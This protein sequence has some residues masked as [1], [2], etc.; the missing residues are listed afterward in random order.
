M[1]AVE[2]TNKPATV[3]G[4]LVTSVAVIATQRT[5][6]TNYAG[7]LLGYLVAVVSG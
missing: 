3:A 2:V 1:F 5:F 6:S 7:G 4:L